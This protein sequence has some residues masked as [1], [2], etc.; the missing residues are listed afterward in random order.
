MSVSIIDITLSNAVGSGL[1]TFRARSWEIRDG[2]LICFGEELDSRI[3]YLVQSKEVAVFPL[4]SV[5]SFYV[6]MES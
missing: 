2:C 4:S 1:I 5:V 6:R 3:K